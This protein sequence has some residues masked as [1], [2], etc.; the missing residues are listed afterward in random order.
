MNVVKQAAIATLQEIWDNIDWQKTDARRLYGIWDEFASKIKA[1]A[2]TTNKYE[3]FVEKLCKKLEIR[4]LK[5]K[6][7]SDITALS[8]EEKT[9]ILKIVRTETTLLVLE[10]RL[11]SENRRQLSEQVRLK[12]EEAAV[13]VKGL[14]EAQVKIKKGGTKDE[15]H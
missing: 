15:K 2:M 3:T 7:V 1:A 10:I 14:N 8:E 13:Q 4:S 11:N 5:S 9:Q 12:K 6:T